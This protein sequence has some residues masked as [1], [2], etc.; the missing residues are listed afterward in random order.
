MSS[1]RQQKQKTNF[2]RT[3]NIQ[4]ED[5]GAQK[6]IKNKKT[7]SSLVEWWV[8]CLFSSMLKT[9]NL[10]RFVSDQ[11]WLNDRIFNHFVF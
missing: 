8:F 6:K 4:Y 5:R 1:R 3:K 7:L 10:F 2:R 9:E 11:R